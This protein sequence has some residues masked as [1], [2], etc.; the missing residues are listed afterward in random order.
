M[1]S[2]F[3]GMD[4]FIEANHLWEDFHSKLISEIERALSDRVP[5]RYVVRT[6]ERSFVA[7][8]QADDYEEK[9]SILPDVAVAAIRGTGKTARKP[10]G[11]ARAPAVQSEAGP[12]IMR[13]L[14]K[15]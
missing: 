3:P 2:P 5:D 4:P 8:A 13:A 9:R 11:S 15:E 7:L 12:V 1:H 6:G 14:V 10:K